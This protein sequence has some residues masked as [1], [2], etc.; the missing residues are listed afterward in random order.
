MNAQGFPVVRK[1]NFYVNDS[2]MH[3]GILKVLNPSATAQFHN[4]RQSGS[5][6]RTRNLLVGVVLI[7]FLIALGGCAAG[8][9]IV[10]GQPPPTVSGSYTNANLNG[11]Y[12][13][14]IRGTNTG[15]F[16]VA[17]NFQANGAGMI[18]AGTEDIN[19]P[20][21]S[22]VMNN[23]AITGTYTVLADGRATANIVS[24]AGNFTLDF[25][26]LSNQ[27]GLAMRFN[28]NSTA[29]GSIDLQD[30]TAFSATSLQGA[31]AFSLLGSDHAGNLE[32]TAGAFTTLNTN[33]VNTIQ[34]GVQDFNDNG[35][36]SANRVLTGSLANPVTGRGTALLTTNVA[37]M[38]FIYYIVDANH[39]LLLETD[40]QT[41]LAG[42]AFRQSGAA[43]PA[44]LVLTM[45]GSA[46][47]LSLGAGAI[48]KTDANNNVLTGSTEDVNKS[49]TVTQNVAV[50]GVYSAITNG[51]GTITLPGSTGL[52]NVAVYPTDSGFLLIS[53]DGSAVATGTGFAQQITTPSNSS[54]SGRYGFSLAGSNTVGPVDAIAQFTG[55]GKG[56][57]SGNLDENSNGS[58][59]SGLSLAGTYSLAATGRGTSAL[60][61]S[62]GTMNLILYMVDASDFIFLEAD[63]GQ[64]ATG[65]IKTQQ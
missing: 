62:A 11:S 15:F 63:T 22:I 25:I 36:I 56:S 54:L 27:H 9:R 30:S 48:L 50:S 64:V 51:R 17:G 32:T 4:G 44:T 26:L 5:Y 7:I 20:G 45:S 6:M 35:V 19:S 61:S 41:V 57:I 60:T 14:L 23:V 16:S 29:S 46:G 49:G 65:N 21:T 34:T 53:I 39:L 47:T 40:T 3:G 12:A 55:D 24:P 18:T 37:A 43:I 8:T 31:Y 38:N 33:N 2:S 52:T 58:L 42:N 59:G 13:F 1:G 10:N 28:T